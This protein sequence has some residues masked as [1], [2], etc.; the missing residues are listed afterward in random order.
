MGKTKLK[1]LYYRGEGP[2]QSP[3][4]DPGGEAPGSFEG[5]VI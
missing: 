1:G 5:P 3:G 4:V 2:G